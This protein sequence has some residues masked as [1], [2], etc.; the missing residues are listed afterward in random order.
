M[1]DVHLREFDASR[2]GDLMAAATRTLAAHHGP[3]GTHGGGASYHP[4]A[5][6]AAHE[7]GVIVAHG[8]GE[9]N[10]Y[11]K[12]ER[13]G[14]RP[15][16]MDPRDALASMTGLGRA[17]DRAPRDPSKPFVPPPVMKREVLDRMRAEMAASADAPRQFDRKLRRVG[18][19]ASEAPRFTASM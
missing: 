16:P 17:K 5:A 13:T 3:L 7:A 18:T 4:R 12:R 19:R 15:P 6:K 10:L 14:P 9:N 8:K 2:G 1:A 11:L